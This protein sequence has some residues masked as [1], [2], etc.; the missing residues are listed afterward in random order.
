MFVLTNA[1][2]SFMDGL[3]IKHN[4]ST[5]DVLAW[6]LRITRKL[7]HLWAACIANPGQAKLWKMLGPKISAQ[8]PPRFAIEA[9][10]DASPFD[11]V[12]A[13]IATISPNMI[14]S[15]VKEF[16]VKA[17]EFAAAGD[18]GHSLNVYGIPC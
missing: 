14:N 6:L 8:I 13:V 17:D 9:P 15:A 4:C 1:A 18:F 11:V 16:K 2:Q 12:K 5:G 10:Y 3:D 7:R